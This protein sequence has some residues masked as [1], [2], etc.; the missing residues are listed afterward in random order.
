MLLYQVN[1][2]LLNIVPI[3]KIRVEML[4]FITKSQNI[5]RIN[6]SQLKPLCETCWMR[7]NEG[8]TALSLIST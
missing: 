5:W 4:V 3:G 1:T 7:E 2:I 6:Q 8:V